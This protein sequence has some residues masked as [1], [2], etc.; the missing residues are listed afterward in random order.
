MGVLPSLIFLERSLIYEKVFNYFN[1]CL[2]IFSLTAFAST[3]LPSVPSFVN[4]SYYLTKDD[5]GYYWCYV[6]SDSSMKMWVDPVSRRVHG[7]N[8]SAKIYY[9]KYNG[10][11]WVNPHGG[12]IYDDNYTYFDSVG[13]YFNAFYGGNVTFYTDDTYSIVYNPAIIPPVVAPTVEKA[14]QG[15][16][17]QLL[18][19]LQEYLPIGVMLLSLM[20]GV[21][22][23]PRLVRSFL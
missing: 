20:L 15:I 12:S 5:D 10:I 23:V 22:L 6:W 1:F 2:S 13:I 18:N 11:E 17:P 7:S 16:A 4:D 9:L 19:Q 8:T 3:D 14:I 21:Y